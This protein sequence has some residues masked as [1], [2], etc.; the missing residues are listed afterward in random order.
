MVVPSVGEV[1]TVP[2]PFSDL[3][4]SKI[5]PALC[6]AE[7]G[8]GDWILGQITRTAY[9]DPQAVRLDPTDFAAG[10]LRMTSYARPGK[11]F[12]ANKGIMLRSV[13]KLKASSIASLLDKVVELIRLVSGP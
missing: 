9:T 13:A 6:I 11:L 1:V 12:T 10:G 5:R 2:F 4:Q 7:S 3:S 8:R